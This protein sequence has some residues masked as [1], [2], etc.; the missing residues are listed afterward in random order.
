MYNR[1]LQPLSSDT[2]V[3]LVTVESGASV[4]D[5]GKQLE[6]G[7]IIR[8]AWA[9]RLYVSS[10]DARSALQAG[11][12]EL[13]PSQSVADIVSLLTHG[14]VATNLVTI[15][16]GQRIDQI[17]K[18]LIQEGFK[19]A[20]VD[21]ALN[22]D[23][24]SGHPA[25]VDKPA[26]ATLEGYLYPESYQRT[27]ITEV[28]SIIKTALDQMHERLTPTLRAGFAKQ[29][30]S[31]YE[32]ITL[33]SIVENEVPKQEDRHKVA[34]VFLKRLRIGMKLESDATA[35]YGAVLA[36]QKPSSRFDSA[37]NTYSN[38][39]LPPSPITNVTESSLKAVAQPA[40]T[41]WT[42]F[43]SGD[44]G[45]THFSQTLAEH[46]ANV[47]RYCTKLCGN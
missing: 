36:G 15:L 17:R 18:R 23:S 2:S 33:A 20:D 38:T 21:N 4:D 35:S 41:D 25:L 8:S 45:T 14:K 34:Q 43:V 13:S 11:D 22:P 24:Y 27:S 29:G 3:K 47:E 44:D 40:S 42:Y 37:Y 5:I 46:E 32:A 1:N 12:Y 31:T 39:G 19:E 16:P 9:F 28:G 26:G 7:G 6:E 10:K 30:L